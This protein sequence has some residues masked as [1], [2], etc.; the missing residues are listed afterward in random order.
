MWLRKNGLTAAAL[1]ALLFIV[2]L[3]MTMNYLPKGYDMRFHYYRLYTIAEGLRD[4]FFPVK[5]QPE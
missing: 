5:I 2:E 3:P 4:G 1:C